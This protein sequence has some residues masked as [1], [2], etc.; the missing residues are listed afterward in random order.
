[1][2][3]TA[4]ASFDASV[5]TGA[6]IFRSWK[7]MKTPVMI[8]LW[9]LNALYWVGFAYLARE[10]AVWVVAAY[11]AVAPIVTAMAIAQRGL[12]RLSGLIHLPWV[13]LVVYLFLR[14]FTDTLGPALTPAADGFYYWWLQ[15]TL[16]S[17]AICVALDILDVIRWIGGERYV[18]GTPEAA[19]AGASKLARQAP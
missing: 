5:P 18:L 9:Y 1:M 8:W 4:Q 6:A 7:A 10:E 14:L 3:G 17:T 12:T 13:P 11:F 19:A 16:W 2:T 15:V